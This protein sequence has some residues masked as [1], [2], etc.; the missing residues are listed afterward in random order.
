MATLVRVPEIPSGR[1][2]AKDKRLAGG[3]VRHDP[4]GVCARSASTGELRRHDR[5]EKEKVMKQ[6]HRLFVGIDWAKDEHTIC[7]LDSEQKVIERCTIEH[8]GAGLGGLGDLL[9]KLSEGNPEN[10]AVAIETPRGAVAET[11]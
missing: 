10:V 1:A 7:V 8:T 3:D 11:H 2:P 9:A 5:P 6:Q 4:W